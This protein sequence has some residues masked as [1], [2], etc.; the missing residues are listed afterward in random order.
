[1]GKALQPLRGEGVLIAGS[2]N[3]YHNM[4]ILMRT[5]RNGGA[6]AIVD[7]DFDRWLS[8]AECNADPETRNRMLTAW[9]D[10]PGERDAHPREEHL[11]PLHV[12]AGAAGSDIGK[13]TLED[14]VMGAVESAFQF[15]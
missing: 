12:V 8:D 14:H 5:M 13:K 2:G 9:A 11:M 1:M 15:G 3:S 10:A 4:G 6:G 7:R